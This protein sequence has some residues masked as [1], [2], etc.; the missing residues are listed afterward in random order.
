[1]FESLFAVPQE[2]PERD[3][4]TCV[5]RPADEF[6]IDPVDFLN[7]F[8]LRSPNIMWL[9]GAGASAGAGVP[10]AATLTWEIKRQLYCTAHRLPATRFPNLNDRTFREKVQSYFAAL[11]GFPA[12]GDIDE[13]AFYF[14]RY[15]PDET[16]RRRFIEGRLNGVRP[17]YGHACLAALIA[18]GKVEVVWTT[19][20][21]HL[22][23]RAAAQTGIAERIPQGLTV[24]SFDAPALAANAIS[25]GRWPLLVKLHGDF[26]YRRLASTADEVQRNDGTSRG[27]LTEEC[28]RRGLAVVGYSG[29]DESVMSALRHAVAARDPFPNGLFWFVRSGEQVPANVQDLIRS[30]RGRN[31]QAGF[32]EIG[33]FDEIMADLFLPHEDDLPAVRDVV[34]AQRERRRPVAPVYAGRDWPVLRT[35][36]LEITKYPSS[37]A[38]FQADIGGAREVKELVAAHRARVTVGRRQAGVVGFG[39]RA[40]LQQLFEAHQ[41]R[42]FERYPIESRRLRHDSIEL[43]L[44]YDAVCQALSVQ[45]GLCRSQNHKGRVLYLR[46]P[47]ILRP[48]DV[49]A[50]QAL[51]ITPVRK[52][53]PKG[54]TVHEAVRISLDYCDRRLWL[55]LEPTLMITTNG[56][57]PY[58]GDDRPDIGREDLVRR[59]NQKASALLTLWIAFLKWKCGGPLRLTFPTS[60]EPE[61]EFEVSTVTAY[62]RQAK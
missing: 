32:V 11:A 6:R 14:Q 50:F 34:K 52:P 25:G 62:A 4:V 45:T 28:G 37:C 8:P 38:V 17:S 9:L 55:L 35:N 7:L 10:T 42:E 41:P 29:R 15:L 33:G 20:F 26:L 44:F 47:D 23:E 59:Y 54:P 12:D 24:A 51:A 46:S 40:D 30:A 49:G 16:D 3:E 39:T 21:D 27:L 57:T 36:A 31:V 56:S 60:S 48:Q 58:T 61:A 18:I 1:M 22:I 13:Y 5:N 43:G 2:L 19:N 53:K